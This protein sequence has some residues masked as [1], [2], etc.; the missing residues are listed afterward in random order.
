MHEVSEPNAITLTADA[1]A[2]YQAGAPKD[3][4]AAM[5]LQAAVY[6]SVEQIGGRANV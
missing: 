1:L 2:A 4:L 5:M 3:Q 6:L